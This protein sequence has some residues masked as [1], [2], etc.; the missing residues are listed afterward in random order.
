MFSNV[1]SRLSVL[2]AIAAVAGAATMYGSFALAGPQDG[3]GEPPAREGR[4]RGERGPGRPEGG[5]VEGAMK[6]MNRA[7]KQLQAIVDD[8]SKRD[9]ALKAIGEMERACIAAKNLG[10]PADALKKATDDAAKAK[11][12][13]TFRSDLIAVMRKL[14]DV[15]QSIM[16]GKGDVAKTQLAEVA[17]L[18]DEAHKALGV[19]D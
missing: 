9:D 16:D 1:R 4:A 15:E 10:A 2:L 5:S 18:R 12:A 6:G 14:L 8:S 17:K 13:D 11:L 3:G 7:L 19:K